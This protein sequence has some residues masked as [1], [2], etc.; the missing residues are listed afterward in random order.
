MEYDRIIYMDADN[1]V[2]QNL[3]D[4]FLCGHFCAIFMNA[5]AFHTGLFVVKPDAEV[6]ANMLAKLQAGI[7]SYDGAD[8]GFL[9]SYFHDMEYAPMFNSSA[10]KKSE[11]KMNRIPI[12]YNMNHIYYYER[13][14]WDVMYR[15]GQWTDLEIP[16]SSIGYPIAQ[17]FKVC[18]QQHY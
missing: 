9:V 11:D 17:T 10:K 15:R 12:N 2:L 3:D 16:A 14:R 6:Y 1:I 4:L 18:F 5:V 13:C 7:T 8:Q